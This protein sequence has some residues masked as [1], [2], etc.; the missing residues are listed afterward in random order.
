MN[1]HF[2]NFL[3]PELGLAFFLFVPG[4]PRTFFC[5]LNIAPNNTFVP[6]KLSLILV[7]PYTPE[8]KKELENLIENY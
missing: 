5:Y 4:L 7:G 1:I 6:E 8:L 3:I 2:V